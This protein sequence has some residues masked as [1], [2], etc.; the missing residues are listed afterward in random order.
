MTVY[1][2]VAKGVTGRLVNLKTQ[3]EQLHTT[4]E[5][6]SFGLT[7]VVFDPVSIYEQHG[8]VTREY[9]FKTGNAVQRETYVF[10]ID[11]KHV[12]VQDDEYADD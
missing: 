1:Y 10:V 3:Q 5:D 7:D 8:A 2:N 12:V 6:H 4:R 11:S 9:A